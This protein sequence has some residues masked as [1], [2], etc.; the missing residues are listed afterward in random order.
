MS[1]KSTNETTDLMAI[2]P[3]CDHPC[4]PGQRVIAIQT[5]DGAVLFHYDCAPVANGP[6]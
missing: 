6:H 5:K 1:K 2:C 3:H 4:R